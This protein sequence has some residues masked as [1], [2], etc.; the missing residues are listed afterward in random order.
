MPVIIHKNGLTEGLAAKKLGIEQVLSNESTSWLTQ[1]LALAKKY[2]QSHA[3]FMWEDVH[4][5]ISE[6]G[7][8]EPHHPNVWGAL[9]NRCAKS[10]WMYRGYDHGPSV[11]PKNKGSDYGVW[12]S[13]LYKK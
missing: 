7:L 13:M 2:I 3:S 9:C 11:R 5:F 8:G 10:G 4:L 12:I 1:A 6:A